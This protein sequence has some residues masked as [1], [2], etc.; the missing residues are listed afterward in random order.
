MSG[1]ARL[2]RFALLHQRNCFGAI[3]P[4]KIDFGQRIQAGCACGSK[5]HRALRVSQRRVR[6]I[7]TFCAK[8]G[9]LVFVSGTIG[10]SG[11]GLDALKLNRPRAVRKKLSAQ[12]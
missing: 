12:M 7:S 5:L 6:F 9:D 2:E 4:M 8:P 10:D 1:L 3:A 11:G